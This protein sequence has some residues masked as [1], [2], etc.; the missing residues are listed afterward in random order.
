[1][2]EEI[3]E[4]EV[5]KVVEELKELNEDQLEKERQK[6]KDA[7]YIEKGVEYVDYPLDAKELKEKYMM[8]RKAEIDSDYNTLSYDEMIAQLDA[9][10]P[11]RL[12]QDS[13]DEMRKDLEEGMITKTRNGVETRTKATEAEIEMIKIKIKSLEKERDLNLPMRNLRLNI[14]RFKE[15]LDQ[16]DSPGKQIPKLRKAIREKK[17]TVLSTRVKPNKIPTG[18]C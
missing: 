8:L 15:S 7:A 3:T 6:A 12:L 11:A 18:V 13:I 14:S 4:K 2:N 16:P 10:L 9:N 5:E 17:E 1:M